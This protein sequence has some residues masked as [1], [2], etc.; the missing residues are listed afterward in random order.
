M[1]C[2]GCVSN[3]GGYDRFHSLAPPERINSLLFSFIWASVP[4][5]VSVS[6]FLVFVWQGNELTIGTAF[7]VCLSFLQH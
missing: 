6:T 1:A 7:T 5:L 2:Q 3:A 4:I